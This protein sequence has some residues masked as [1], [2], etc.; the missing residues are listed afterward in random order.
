MHQAKMSSNIRGDAKLTVRAIPLQHI[1]CLRDGSQRSW[2]IRKATKKTLDET[3]TSLNLLAKRPRR[4]KT[5]QDG[6]R[7]GNASTK[8]LWWCYIRPVLRHL[9]QEVNG[10]K[11]QHL[12]HLKWCENSR[13]MVKRFDEN[14]ELPWTTEMTIWDRWQSSASCCLGVESKINAVTIISLNY[15]GDSSLWRCMIVYRCCIDAAVPDKRVK[16]RNYRKKRTARNAR[17]KWWGRW[18][19]YFGLARE[20]RLWECILMTMPETKTDS[21]RWNARPHYANESHRS[22][23]EFGPQL[24]VPQML[25][26]K[27][28]K[29]YKATTASLL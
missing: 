11:W 26:T 8:R 5:T 15:T 22:R 21:N 13:L 12:Q 17:A 23:T 18:M 28:W 20:W 29:V 3:K 10:P 1:D 27:S 25:M 19:S 2:G 9:Y 6:W 24:L 7:K 16:W 14:N 4:G